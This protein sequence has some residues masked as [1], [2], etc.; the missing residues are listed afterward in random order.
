MNTVSVRILCTFI[1]LLLR[2]L[3]LLFALFITPFVQFFYQIQQEKISYP[4]NER[5]TAWKMLNCTIF[6]SLVETYQK[7]HSFVDTTPLS[8]GARDQLW[9]SRLLGKLANFNITRIIPWTLVVNA[10]MAV[11]TLEWAV[12]IGRVWKPPYMCEGICNSNVWARRNSTSLVV[13]TLF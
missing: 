13:M 10:R 6:Y 3:K 2:N 8:P 9:P 4:W 1:D 5:I 7:T 11:E 12:C